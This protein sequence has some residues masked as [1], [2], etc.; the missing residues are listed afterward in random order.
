MTLEPE[1][2]GCWQEGGGCQEQAGV[3]PSLGNVGADSPGEERALK[4]ILH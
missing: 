1:V 2:D 3:N 4:E